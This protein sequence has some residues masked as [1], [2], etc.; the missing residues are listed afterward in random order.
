MRNYD[1]LGEVIIFNSQSNEAEKVVTSSTIEFA[2]R[3]NN[4][5]MSRKGEVIA[6]DKDDNRLIQFTK[7]DTD[8]RV[9]QSQISRN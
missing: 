2:S 4:C 9:L 1:Q 3:F 8:M 6:I 5:M 7:G